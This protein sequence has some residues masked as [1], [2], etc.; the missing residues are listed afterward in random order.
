MATDPA[1]SMRDLYYR[2]SVNTVGSH[3]MIYNAGNYGN[4]YQ[5]TMAEYLHRLP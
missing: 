1:I 4:M 3:V 2:L 5:E